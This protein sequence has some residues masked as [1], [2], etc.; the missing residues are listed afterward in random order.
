L[1]GR[2]DRE[3]APQFVARVLTLTIAGGVMLM[4][5]FVLGLLMWL[6]L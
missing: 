4:V 2:R 6:L 3:D 5:V 1:P